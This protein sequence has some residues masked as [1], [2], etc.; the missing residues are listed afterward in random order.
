MNTKSQFQLVNRVA[1]FVFLIFAV[2]CTGFFVNPTL[3]SIAV[4]PQTATIQ[5]GNTL[6]M[7]STGTYSDGSTQSLTGKSFW[8]S[9]DSTTASVN[10]TGL[11]TGVSPGTATITASSG[12]VTGSTTITISLANI[13]SIAVTPTNS[14]T[15]QGSTVQFTA[16][17]TVAGGGT[18]DITSSATWNSS[19][20]NAGTIDT[21]GLF[22]ASP[23][24]S[25]NQATSITATSGN[26]TGQTTMTVTP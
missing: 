11:V 5:Q 26:V 21:N 8:S 10:S 13:T 16:T 2:G 9:S 7:A 18:Q 14:S 22:T 6:Q 12:T 4:G 17:A 3:N 25:A 15:I 24:V 23:S 1:V 19:N 20:S